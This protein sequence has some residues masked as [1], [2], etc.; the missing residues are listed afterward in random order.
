M[1]VRIYEDA[2]KGI[3][4][5]TADIPVHPLASYDIGREIVS[6][7]ES[8]NTKEMVCLAGITVMSD[9]HRV[10]GAVSKKE[11]LDQDKGHDRGLRAGDDYRHY[12]QHHER[13]Q[14]SEYAGHLPFR[15]DCSAPSLI[16]EQR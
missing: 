4:V 3:V 1:P 5:L 15:R 2:G 7:A 6:W 14:H 12:G 8:I 10:F 11:M 9:Q 13:V 16:P